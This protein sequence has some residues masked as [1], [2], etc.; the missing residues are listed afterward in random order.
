MHID[1]YR[2]IQ[3]NPN[4]TRLYSNS[5]SYLYNMGLHCEQNQKGMDIDVYIELY[6]S[7]QAKDC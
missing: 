6:Y 5:L 4:H 7:L 3:S 2:K 1:I